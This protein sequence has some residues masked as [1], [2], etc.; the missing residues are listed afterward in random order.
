MYNTLNVKRSNL[1]S[2]NKLSAYNDE[3]YRRNIKFA[4]SPSPQPPSS[5]DSMPSFPNFNNTNI[6]KKHNKHHKYS[7]KQKTIQIQFS[8]KNSKDANKGSE[9]AS[10][11]HVSSKHIQSTSL[12]SE[13]TVSSTEESVVSSSSDMNVESFSE[14]YHHKQTRSSITLN[15]MTGAHKLEFLQNIENDDFNQDI[16]IIS[17]TSSTDHSTD[18]KLL[19]SISGHKSSS[20]RN[21]KKNKKTSFHKSKEGSSSRSRKKRHTKVEEKCET[22]VVESSIINSNNINNINNKK[23]NDI[24]TKEWKLMMKE[25]E[26][27]NLQMKNTHFIQS[28]QKEIESLKKELNIER[29]H[30]QRHKLSSD[31]LS[32]I[33]SISRE[34]HELRACVRRFKDE[35]IFIQ[36]QPLPMSNPYLKNEMHY[37]LRSIAGINHINQQNNHKFHPFHHQQQSRHSIITYDLSNDKSD[38]TVGSSEW[39]MSR[40]LSNS[41]LDNLQQSQTMGKLFSTESIAMAQME[42]NY[43]IRKELLDQQKV[44]SYNYIYIHVY[45]YVLLILDSIGY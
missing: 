6:I 3:Y 45:T 26:I 10:P 22:V 2:S 32:M 31:Q 18:N 12:S 37:N 11:A 19:I 15:L 34:N 41:S 44:N 40:L 27:I 30:N 1:H 36:S 7:R 20:S 14:K 29:N 8:T 13:G 21:V 28:L 43:C 4:G 38:M 23:E 16:N 42:K 17:N 24:L 5:T 33:D 25:E 9:N 39:T 35:M